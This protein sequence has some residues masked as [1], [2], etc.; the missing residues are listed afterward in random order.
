MG[1][2]SVPWAY[3][4]IPLPVDD[5]GWLAG[6]SISKNSDH[7][8]LLILL[9]RQPYPMSGRHFRI[10]KTCPTRKLHLRTEVGALRYR[11]GRR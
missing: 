7:L 3:R 10:S 11:S 6:L 9:S 1:Q 4:Y 8:I 5:D 2:V